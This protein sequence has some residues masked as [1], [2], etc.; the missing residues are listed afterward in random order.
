MLCRSIRSNTRITCPIDIR[1]GSINFNTRMLVYQNRLFCNWFKSNLHT[2]YGRKVIGKKNDRCTTRIFGSS[3][4][5]ATRKTETYNKIP[6][7][8]GF[9]KCRLNTEASQLV[10]AD[11]LYDDRQNLFKMVPRNTGAYSSKNQ[12]Q[13]AN[14][15]FKTQPIKWEKGLEVWR[16]NPRILPKIL[17]H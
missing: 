11:T 1:V 14:C 12:S 10:N 7:Y 3:P 15:C 17:Q 9:I 5:F 8:T 13:S 6:N 2:Q 16:S 4:T